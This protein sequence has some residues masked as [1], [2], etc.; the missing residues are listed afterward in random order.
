MAKYGT[1]VITLK[2]R[3]CITLSQGYSK[4]MPNLYPRPHGFNRNI[5]MNSVSWPWSSA[6]YPKSRL[7]VNEYKNKFYGSQLSNGN[8]LELHPSARH[9]DC[10][11][12]CKSSQ[13]TWL[14]VSSNITFP[15]LRT[16]NNIFMNCYID[17]EISPVTLHSS[18]VPWTQCVSVIQC[19][20]CLTMS[21]Y[22][23]GLADW[24]CGTRY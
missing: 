18:I 2:I 4:K 1:P 5:L 19:F 21:W 9:K 20:E 16:F 6:I 23:K 10:L 15:S 8:T 22:L 12:L 24:L 14:D 13:S 17:M 3:P 11:R 7:F